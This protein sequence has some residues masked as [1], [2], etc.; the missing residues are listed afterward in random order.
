MG[1]GRDFLWLGG[2]LFWLG[3]DEWGSVGDFFLA[4]WESVGVGG[5]GKSHSPRVISSSPWRSGYG[6]RTY[7]DKFVSQNLI[8]AGSSPAGSVGRDLNLQNLHYQYLTTSV[9]VVLAVRHHY[10]NRPIK[11]KQYIQ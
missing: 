10:E 7:F 4:W 5:G 3:G 1:I 6:R 11:R 9:A 2:D 8:G